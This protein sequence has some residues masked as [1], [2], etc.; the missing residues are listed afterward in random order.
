MSGADGEITG[1]L[2]SSRISCREVKSGWIQVKR[3]GWILWVVGSLIFDSWVDVLSC[4]IGEIAEGIVPLGID[5][6][7]E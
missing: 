4:S 2:R 7:L 3:Q 6:L 5:G 1:Y